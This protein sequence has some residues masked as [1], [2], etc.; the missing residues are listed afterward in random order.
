MI[1]IRIS[2][3]LGG[4]IFAVTSSD[5]T[6]RRKLGEEE[7]Q[8]RWKTN[9]APTMRFQNVWHKTAAARTILKGLQSLVLNLMSFL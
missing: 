5:L 6:L 1:E 8:E 7:V 4:A 2:T 9:D 3:F